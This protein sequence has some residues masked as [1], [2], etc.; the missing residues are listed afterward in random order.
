MLTSEQRERIKKDGYFLI[1]NAIEPIGLE[2]VQKAY[3][4]IQER[5]ESAWR[6]SV[7]DGTFSGGYGNGPNAHTMSKVGEQNDIFLDLANNPK[8]I[9]LLKEIVGP[10]LQVGSGGVCHCH[11]AGAD[12]HTAWHRDWAPY[13]HPE[14]V[15]K[16]KVFYFL[17][18]Q[19]VDMGCFSL[20]PGTHKLPDAPP[21]DKYIGSSLEEMPGLVKIVG[22]AGS[23]ILWNVLCW[24]TG[25][26]NTSQ[27][28]R[29]IVIYGYT[30]FWIKSGSES[31]RPKQ[32][33]I[34]WA[35]TPEKRELVGIHAIHG[36]RA[37]DRV[38]VP[39]LP[40]HEKIAMEKKF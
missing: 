32:K 31:D 6:Q 37:W 21:K 36:R 10:D 22:S 4:R 26:A 39:Y 25:L 28:D 30:P 3:E 38:D 40:E 8:V 12:A 5:T 18:D 35:D 19:E 11:H 2:R 1:E 20:V 29:R 17:D 24:H 34:D 15:I 33:I 16:A 27:N 14:Y 9:P 13:T 23:A 7:K